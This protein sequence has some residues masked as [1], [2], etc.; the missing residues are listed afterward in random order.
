M[1]CSQ[2]WVVKQQAEAH[3]SLNT[4]TAIEGMLTSVP[5]LF[6]N[7][8]KMFCSP[9]EVR[10]VLEP[11]FQRAHAQLVELLQDT[12]CGSYLIAEIMLTSGA[13]VCRLVV[14]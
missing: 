3:F 2:A 8:E 9:S 11:L 13:V 14:C 12:G 7:C 6:C 10:A 5:R 1:W 4:S